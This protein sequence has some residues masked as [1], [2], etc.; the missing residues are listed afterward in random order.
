M[1]NPKQVGDKVF[2]SRSK[3]G[4]AKYYFRLATIDCSTAIVAL[5]YA[6]GGGPLAVIS[7]FGQ[8]YYELRHSPGAAADVC[9]RDSN[10]RI[11]DTARHRSYAVLLQRV[12]DVRCTSPIMINHGK[13]ASRQQMSRPA[14]PPSANG[15][16]GILWL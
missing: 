14:S 7:V 1:S 13:T 12:L 9:E 8:R 4:S 5:V 2:N 16:K 10:R 3:H 6:T 11:P 15:P